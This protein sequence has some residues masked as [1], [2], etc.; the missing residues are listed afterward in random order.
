V[1][2][3]QLVKRADGFECPIEIRIRQPAAES[4][5]FDPRPRRD[6]PRVDD[7]TVERIFQ[8]LQHQ[9]GFLVRHRSRCG[10]LVGPTDVK[11]TAQE[12]VF[13]RHTLRQPEKIRIIPE[14]TDAQE[15]DRD[16]ACPRRLTVEYPWMYRVCL[17]IRLRP[18]RLGMSLLPARLRLARLRITMR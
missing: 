6:D 10:I 2:F 1:G 13:I 17:A 3:E 11:A 15:L 12:A 9:S 7:H 16:N 18:L 14:I 5:V 8:G 4:I